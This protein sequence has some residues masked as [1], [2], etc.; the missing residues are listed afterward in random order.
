LSIIP[1][2]AVGN[3]IPLLACASARPSQVMCLLA[4]ANC[5]PFDYV[6]RQKISGNTMNFFIVK[7]FPV[8][9]PDHYLPHLLDYIVPRAVELTYTAWDLQPFAR[10]ILDEV[11]P[12]TWAQWFESAPVHTS[13]PPTWA[14]GATPPPFVWDEGRRARLRA[15][16]DALY[17]HLYGLAREELAYILDTFPIVR[18]KDEAQYG[19]YRTKRMVLEKYDGLESVMR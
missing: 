9:P 18:R 19:E 6:T 16:L 4:N 7:Q 10:D 8:L 17:G 13:P 12:E 2:A 14:E 1:W 3:K 11:G 5:I 15:E